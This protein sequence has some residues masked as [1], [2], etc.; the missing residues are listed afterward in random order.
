MN[1]INWL[2][3]PVAE[4]LGWTLIH[5]LWQGFVVVCTVALLLHLTRRSR[6]ALRYQIGISGLLGQVL[7]SA[8]TFGWYYEPTQA[9]SQ[10]AL[11]ASRSL[12]VMT[13]QTQTS[14]LTA[15]Q[16][17]LNAHLPEVVWAWL[18]GVGLFG[19]R[20]V[21]GWLYV[22]RLRQ[23]A[24]LPVPTAL[25]E[26]ADRMARQLDVSARLQVTARVTGPLVVGILKP[27]VL[28]PMGML[29]HLSAADVE[30][31]LAHELAHVRRHDYLLNLLQSVIE[32]VYFFHPA[33]WWLSARVRE[34]REHCCDDSAVAVVGDAR[35]LA[36]ALARVEEWQRQAEEVPALAL[37]FAG[38][39]QL[40]LHRVRRMLGV[41]TKPLVSNNSLAGLTLLTLLLVSVSV[42]AVGRSEEPKVVRYEV[43]KGTSFGMT[44][45][46]D[47]QY[48]NWQGKRVSQ[49]TLDRLQAQLNGLMSGT[50]SIRDVAENDRAILKMIIQNRYL[51]TAEKRE[52]YRKSE[53]SLQAQLAAQSKQ[54][55]YITAVS[56]KRTAG[57]DALKKP[58]FVIDSVQIEGKWYRPEEYLKL[59]E[60]KPQSNS[61][62]RDTSRLRA[63]QRE[64][65][66]LTKKMQEDMQK[67][68]PAL[69][70]LSAEM[71]ELSLKTSDYH[72]RLE[73]LAK[74]MGE[75]GQKQGEL[76]R[77]QVAVHAE[78][79]RLSRLSDAKSRALLL[80]KEQQSEQLERQMGELE[81]QMEKLG[82]QFEP[83]Q[84]EME[85]FHQRMSAIGDSISRLAEPTQ[86][87]SEKIGELSSQIAE[88]AYEQAE[89]AMRMADDAFRAMEFGD[90]PARAPRARV[91]RTPG[92]SRGMVAP[93][94]PRYPRT[95]RAAYPAY[96]PAP[97]AEALTP[98]AVPP[99]PPEPYPRP[100]TRSKPAPTPRPA[101]AP[102]PAT[103]PK[104]PTGPK[105]G[106]V[107][108]D[109]WQKQ[110]DEALE[111]DLTKKDEELISKVVASIKAVQQDMETNR[112]LKVARMS[113]GDGEKIKNITATVRNAND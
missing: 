60:T 27:V 85:P 8:V 86:E 76:A 79:S 102:R 69:E 98:G 111:S 11:P 107:N 103:V 49:P 108:S 43:G 12:F 6:A 38:K 61:V 53:D 13:V 73:P 24:T 26:M 47:L 88:D 56:A 55:G 33:L 18:V 87:L 82:D 35:V 32:V 17:F 1:L 106:R 36:R 105:S 39:R 59:A 41:P 9:V 19:V 62:P 14:W 101:T 48:V 54:D 89:K 71:A 80:Q 68:Q 74:Q 66:A 65:E 95:P 25:A 3:S 94:A 77:K 40:L 44:G 83:T 2:K 37:A 10:L 67:H 46:Y 50:L 52:E 57:P 7:L 63:A 34:E 75:L 5:A 64:L 58:G 93:R 22:E 21:G 29:A 104:P 109:F 110:S 45:R 28:W 30:A 81:K 99:P 31:V 113:F 4:A 100:A 20:L 16:S 78:L 72:K 15:T 91:P 84:R 96:A 70:R 23:T 51:T 112:S 92:V 42:Y 97:P 90:R